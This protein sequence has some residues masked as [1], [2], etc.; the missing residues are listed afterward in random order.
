MKNKPIDL[1]LLNKSATVI[2]KEIRSINSPEEIKI[3]IESEQLNKNRKSVFEILASRYQYLMLKEKGFN[4]DLLTFL[5][6][7]IPF[8]DKS[9]EKEE[10]T[11]KRKKEVLKRDKYTCQ[12]CYSMTRRLTVHHIKPQGS[13]D[14]DNLITLCSGCHNAVHR[15]LRNKGYPYYY[16][17]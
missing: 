8:F 4:T 1:N 15:I 6:N 10:F 5:L 3:L 13:A 17:G 12:L 14:P 7:E 11:E 16:R 2:E 9:K